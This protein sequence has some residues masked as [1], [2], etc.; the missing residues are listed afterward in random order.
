MP[1]TFTQIYIQVVFAVRG[2]QNLLRKEF[3]EE[4]F[5]YIGGI[6]RNPDQKLIIINGMAD[7]IHMLIR[8]RPAT[9]LSDL[10]RDVKAGSSRFINEKRWIRGRFEWQ[11]GYGGFSYSQSD[12]DRIIAYIRN[13]EQHHARYTFREE[14]L[15]LLKEFK[16]EYKSEFLFEWI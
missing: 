9:A 15:E 1:N 10:I 12:L 4:V 3:R 11:E 5:K 14:Y 6:A 13:R 7:H 16:I 8:Y 2:R